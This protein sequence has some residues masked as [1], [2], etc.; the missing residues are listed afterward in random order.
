MTG[1]K[2]FSA[3]RNLISDAFKPVL[4]LFVI[5]ANAL[6]FYISLFNPYAAFFSKKDQPWN[7]PD[8]NPPA[9]LLMLGI[10]VTLVVSTCILLY[11]LVTRNK[12]FYFAPIFTML[13]I[14]AVWTASLGLPYPSSTSQWEE[15]NHL[16]KMEIWWNRTDGKRIYKRWRSAEVY[17]PEMD[18]DR[19]N[20]ILDS[21][22]VSKDSL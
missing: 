9:V 11:R 10:M 12:I 15:N 4:A 21:M 3:I 19:L 16:Y 5:M 7:M 1:K 18:A 17:K 14:V 2:F 8:S 22:S 13:V 20:Y 6:L